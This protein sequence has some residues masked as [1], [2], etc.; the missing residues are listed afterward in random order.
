MNKKEFL[1][2][3]NYEDKV[4]LSNIYDKISLHEKIGRPVYTNEFYPPVIWKS[5]LKISVELNCKICTYG[6]FDESDRR[7]I[8]IMSKDENDTIYDYPVELLKIKNKSNFSRL[9]HSDFLGALV[10]Q[11]IK[12]EKFGDLILEEQTCYVP[13]CSDI[14]KF[15]KENLVKIGKNPC[16]IETIDIEN[17][18]VPEYKFE[19][20]NIVVTSMRIDAVVAGICGISR[21]VSADMIKKGLILLDYEKIVEKDVNLDIGSIITVRGYGKFKI[22]E[23]IGKTQKGKEKLVIKK[24]I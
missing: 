23:I 9:K 19:K 6:V 2:K 8:S 1:R 3:I 16:E 20:S 10:G 22:H 24:Y 18:K 4:I 17:T 14:S 7:L 11:G 15:I 12:R 5:L 21:N 13:V